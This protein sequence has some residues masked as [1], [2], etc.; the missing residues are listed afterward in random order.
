MADGLSAKQEAFVLAYIGE[1]RFNASK[2]ALIAG[3]TKARARQTGHELVRNSDIAARIAS[4]LKVMALT[5]EQVLAEITDVAVA[6]WRDFITVRTHPQTGAQID[7]R[8]D[9]TSK[10]KALELLGKAHGLFTD[11][12]DIS[13]TL[14]AQVQLVGVDEGDI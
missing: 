12:V 5:S 10:M 8:M 3:Y 11:R 13:G 9:L 6:D 14:T 4:E 7:V 2:A 1:A